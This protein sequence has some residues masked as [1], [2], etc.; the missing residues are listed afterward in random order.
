MATIFGGIHCMAWF[1]A[2]P[3]YQEQVL[4]RM[5]VVAITCSP[6]FTYLTVFL[7]AFLDTSNVM[8]ITIIVFCVMLYITARGV[9]L[10]LMFTTLCDL[11]LDAYK[12][13]LWTSLVP[14][15]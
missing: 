15:L 11:P 5:S 1:F 14:H 13:V 2:F 7:L 10:V 3:T 8:N 9:L 6:W 4:W 12:A